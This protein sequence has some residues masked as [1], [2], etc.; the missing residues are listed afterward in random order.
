VIQL[1]T[2]ILTGS[3]LAGRLI[4]ITLSGGFDLG[5]TTAAGV[6]TLHSKFT[7]QQGS[8]RMKNVKIMP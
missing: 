7:L 4:D 5:Y 1:R 3:L 2:G 6:T 8:V